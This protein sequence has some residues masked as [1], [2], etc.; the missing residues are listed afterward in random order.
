MVQ[1]FLIRKGDTIDCKRLGD[2]YICRFFDETTKKE[3]TIKDIDEIESDFFGPAKVTVV[4][5]GDV[6]IEC[7][8]EC[9]LIVEERRI[10]RAVFP[11]ELR[12]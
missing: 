5:R 2:R 3:V 8:E 11:E 12:E 7:S 1:K 6:Y 9:G 4:R 10:L